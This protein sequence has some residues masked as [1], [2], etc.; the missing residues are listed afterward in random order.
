MDAEWAGHLKNLPFG[1]LEYKADT[2]IDQNSFYSLIS[3]LHIVCSINS[4]KINK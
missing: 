3:N 4:K 2:Y 1:R